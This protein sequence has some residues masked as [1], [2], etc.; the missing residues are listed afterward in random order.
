MVPTSAKVGELGTWPKG[1]PL[2]VTG[3]DAIEI[4][5]VSRTEGSFAD[6]L[7]KAA[8]CSNQSDPAPTDLNGLTDGFE[9]FNFSM[10]MSAAAKLGIPFLNISGTGDKRVFIQDFMFYKNSTDGCGNPVKWGAGVRV[11]ISARS[12]TGSAAFTSLPAVAASTEFRYAE[13]AYRLQTIGI[14]GPKI[15]AA[16]PPAGSYDIE[17]HVA[18][19][20][21]IDDIRKVARDAT[22]IV[23]P[24]LITLVVQ[25]DEIYVDAL[26]RSMA[27]QYLAAGRSCNDAKKGLADGHSAVADAA[28]EG[29]YKELA[30]SCSNDKVTDLVLLARIQV[31]LKSSGWRR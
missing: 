25:E 8:A 3:M 31:F 17:K 12:L 4:N 20:K 9:S 29:V 30:G 1:I 7:F 11:V 24:A 26:S 27:L 19:M 5:G 6:A 14:S 18:L 28:V 23:T 15:D 2:S 13:S 10:T 22:T 21:A 16:V